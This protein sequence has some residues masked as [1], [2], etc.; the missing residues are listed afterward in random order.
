MQ[1]KESG[2]ARWKIMA[3]SPPGTTS[4][5]EFTHS[6]GMRANRRQN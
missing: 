6:N 5:W 3:D 4:G 2:K 1:V